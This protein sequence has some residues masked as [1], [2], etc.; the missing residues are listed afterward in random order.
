MD[1]ESNF[2]TRKEE[3]DEI[4]ATLKKYMG[5]LC[6]AISNVFRVVVFS[7]MEDIFGV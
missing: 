2:P 3:H 1:I 4:N 5:G 6:V 7:V